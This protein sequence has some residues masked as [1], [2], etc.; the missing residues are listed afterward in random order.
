MSLTISSKRIK[1][2]GIILTKKVKDLHSENFKTQ[3]REIEEYIPKNGKIF[4]VHG[5]GESI[6]LKYLYAPKQSIIWCNLN[7]IPMAYFTGQEQIILKFVA[8][9]QKIK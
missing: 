4:N 2:L 7:Q 6:L 1:Y 8:K 5:L 3:M 9:P